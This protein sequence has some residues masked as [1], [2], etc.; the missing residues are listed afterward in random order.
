MKLLTV[1]SQPGLKLPRFGLGGDIIVDRIINDVGVRVETE[2]D[3]AP[4][5]VVEDIEVSL[6]IERARTSDP[7]RDRIIV[8]GIK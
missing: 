7:P 4:D 2:I 8:N 5:A 6:Q 1:E 3:R